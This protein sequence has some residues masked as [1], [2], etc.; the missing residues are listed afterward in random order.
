MKTEVKILKTFGLFILLLIQSV[1]WKLILDSHD[2][3]VI[4][5]TVGGA[6][7]GLVIANVWMD[8]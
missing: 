5:S 3:S 6:V 2:L 8:R 4:M 1:F 7:I